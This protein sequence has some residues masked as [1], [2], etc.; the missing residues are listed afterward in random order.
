VLVHNRDRIPLSAN[1]GDAVDAAPL[2]A[3][4][5]LSD[6]PSKELRWSQL[7]THGTGEV[8]AAN[9]RGRRG[10][11]RLFVSTQSPERLR[12]IALLDPPVDTLYLAQVAP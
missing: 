5:R 9:L 3:T 2:D 12:T 10:W 11:I 7:T 8:W 4:G 1:D 6:Q